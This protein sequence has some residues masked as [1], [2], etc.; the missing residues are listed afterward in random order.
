[1]IATLGR[2]LPL[3]ALL[4]RLKRPGLLAHLFGVVQN[5]GRALA[6]HR[7][8]EVIAS[9]RLHELTGCV[10]APAMDIVV[11]S[12]DTLPNVPDGR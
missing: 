7:G 6:R 10:V 1:M 2:W 5:H 11:E 8:H 12:A 3:G 4:L 9:A